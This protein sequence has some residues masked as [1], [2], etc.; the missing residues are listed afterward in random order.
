[1]ALG[2]PT[3]AVLGTGLAIGTIL[4][5]DLAPTSTP[6]PTG[7]TATPVP[8]RVS[9]QRAGNGRLLVMVSAS[10]PIERVSWPSVPNVV[11]ETADGTPINGGSLVPPSG[12]TTAVFYVRK[13]GGSSATLP[14]TVTG[15]FPTWQTFVGGGPD[16]W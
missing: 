5:D 2:A 4:N 13:T 8:I 7:A 16:A 6:L 14:L 9:A 12:S 1:V 10:G 3:N 11:V 15:A